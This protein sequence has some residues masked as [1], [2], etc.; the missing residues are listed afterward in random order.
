[1]VNRYTEYESFEG[2]ESSDDTSSS[3]YRTGSADDDHGSN[4]DNSNDISN[5]SNNDSKDSS[6]DSCGNSSE[7]DSAK[8]S[9]ASGKGSEES[10]NRERNDKSEKCSDGKGEFHFDNLMEE[11]NRAYRSVV[12]TFQAGALDTTKLLSATNER[13]RNYRGLLL[14]WPWEKGASVEELITARLQHEV[15]YSRVV[16][17]LDKFVVKKSEL[18]GLSNREI[19][20]EMGK[21]VA[22]LLKKFSGEEQ[23]KFMYGKKVV[24]PRVVSALFNLGKRNNIRLK[25]IDINYETRVNMINTCLDMCPAYSF[26]STKIAKLVYRKFVGDPSGQESPVID[27]TTKT[28]L[29]GHHVEMLMSK[30]FL[31]VTMG[32][33]NQDELA[34]ESLSGTAVQLPTVTVDEVITSVDSSSNSFSVV[35]IH[36]FV[37]QVFKKKWVKRMNELLFATGVG[38][39]ENAFIRN[40][41]TTK[42]PAPMLIGA[43]HVYGG[44]VPDE[45][46]KDLLKMAVLLAKEQQK[47]I[48]SAHGLYKVT[49]HCNQ[50]HTVVAAIRCAI[51]GAHSDANP[52]CCSGFES[53]DCYI[54]AKDEIYLP[55]QKEMQVATMVFSN[56]EDDF[57]T[58]LVYTQGKKTLKRIKLSSCCLHWQG[59]GSQAVGI[60]H[61]VQ[62]LNNVIRSGIFRAHS[63]FRYTLD[64]KENSV[65]FNT[66]LSLGLGIRIP[67]VATKWNQSYNVKGVIDLSTYCDAIELT[68]PETCC[69][70]Q[71]SSPLLVLSEDEELPVNNDLSTNVDLYS[72][73]LT[74][75]YDQ[76]PSD[77]Y[78]GHVRPNQC[79]KIRLAGT[80]AQELSSAFAVKELFDAGYLLEVQ[81][82]PNQKAIPCIHKINRKEDAVDSVDSGYGHPVPGKHYRLSTICAD[83][84]LNHSCRSHKI[85]IPNK[86]HQRVIILS[87]SYKNDYLRIRN[88][89]HQL[90]EKVNSKPR[91]PF[92]DDE[93]DGTIWIHG[94]GGAP[95]FP[96]AVPPDANTCSKDD[97]MIEIP[98]FQDIVKNPLNIALTE[99]V[100]GNEVVTIY[101]NEAMFDSV[102][103]QQK[104]HG[105]VSNQGL[106]RCLGIF[107]AVRLVMQSE[108]ELSVVKSHCDDP[109]PKQ[110]FARYKLAPYL[111]VEFKPLLSNT[112]LES[113]WETELTE[114]AQGERTRKR[115]RMKRLMIPF[116][117]K[118]RLETTIPLGR[119]T[120]AS[121]LTPGKMIL[122]ST[123]IKEFIRS[124]RVKKYIVRRKRIDRVGCCQQSLE[125]SSSADER[126]T[127]NCDKLEVCY[128]ESSL[129]DSDGN[130]DSEMEDDDVAVAKTDHGNEAMEKGMSADL[131]GLFSAIAMCSVA[132]AYRFERSCFEQVKGKIYARPLL[133]EVSLP[134]VYRI[135]P[136]PMPNRALDVVS[137]GL[138]AELVSDGT[139]VRC[140]TNAD[141]RIKYKPA[142]RMDLIGTLYKS[143]M[144]R[145][146]GRLNSFL[147]YSLSKSSVSMLP[148]IANTETFL[149]FVGSTV[150]LKRNTKRLSRWISDQHA[151][152]IP[153]ETQNFTGF[154]LFIKRI[155]TK[156]EDVLEKMLEEAGDNNRQRY[157]ASTI[158][159]DLLLESSQVGDREH[160]LNFMA[161]QVLSDVEEIF[162]EPFGRVEPQCV[163]AGSG[164][165]QGFKMLR[166][167]NNDEAPKDLEQALCL[168]MKYMREVATKN[169]L[170]IMGY[171]RNGD[172][173][174]IQN[175]VNGRPFNATD[176]EHFLCKLWVVAKYTLPASTITRQPKATKPHCHP[177]N[178]RGKLFTPDPSLEKIM[179]GILKGH[180]KNKDDL[181]FPHFCL[182]TDEVH[183]TDER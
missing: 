13:S 39:K 37:S 96:G 43:K 19:I 90:N 115:K 102:S 34:N 77:L 169:D 160:K 114:P 121:S 112:D 53:T 154:S 161:H 144:L 58:Q 24:N 151:H 91:R 113:M 3:T 156:L 76:L 18:P 9:E 152:A 106:C 157:K 87:Q 40:C 153:K 138:R 93:F 183:K 174:I 100:L 57:S 123:I 46:E 155:A 12:N 51:Y 118:D 82:L 120:D 83:A 150:Q 26:V 52:T 172:D 17:Q 36:N 137:I 74:D 139:F 134:D 135:H 59:P 29:F 70:N 166:N 73:S 81:T 32:I 92:F 177:V 162:D 99:M 164:A 173:N 167:K 97:P 141:S 178:L 60:Q 111:K 35:V 98:R 182:L 6:V 127:G 146:T 56:C 110:Q 126:A 89:L 61:E 62:V 42:E 69:Y 15:G 175:K 103:D 48:E 131:R 27:L 180:E 2:E 170:E 86:G 128:S 4:N 44:L 165:E 64:P 7:E 88:F 95:S 45:M 149:S 21:T 31:D 65:A 85:Y 117:C 94:S 105:I 14:G 11:A 72:K 142:Y 143:I 107:S 122:R 158:L 181:E 23:L 5:Q 80:M 104:D 147:Q 20:E 68:N 47:M 49:W 8:G 159:R 22:L 108:N 179:T 132:G 119:V 176:A 33:T 116:G 129:S 163:H 75:C 54:H 25:D 140:Q 130:S 1:M 101:V 71:K 145:F 136:L 79:A 41:S 171:Q 50:V 109:L 66:R 84:G 168:I 133:K 30:G 10:R 148:T 55:K 125:K 67:S 124:D 78:N 16:Y 28:Q 63:T 38:G